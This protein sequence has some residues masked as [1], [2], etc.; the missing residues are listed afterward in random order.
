M[1]S[2]SMTH[3]PK[4]TL[5]ARDILILS[6]ILQ[7]ARPGP[8]HITVKQRRGDKH[9]L[10]V[11]NVIA[12][13]LATIDHKKANFVAVT[14]HLDIHGITA[15]VMSCH[16][17]PTGPPVRVAASAQRGAELL[18]ESS[19]TLLQRR[20]SDFD[21]YVADVTSVIQHFCSLPPEESLRQ[22]LLFRF[23]A[24]EPIT[25]QHF[26]L[27]LRPPEAE[28]LLENWGLSV[29][30]PSTASSNNV[31]KYMVSSGNAAQWAMVLRDLVHSLRTTLRGMVFDG[32]D[33]YE[34]VVYQQ[35]WGYMFLL[36]VLLSSGI[37]A[38]LITNALNNKFSG[39]RRRSAKR[40]YI[41]RNVSTHEERAAADAAKRGHGDQSGS[42]ADVTGFGQPKVS[43]MAGDDGDE[44]L[45]SD[46]CTEHRESQA[47][48]HVVQYLKTLVSAL[49]IV[50][51][52]RHLRKSLQTDPGSSVWLKVYRV[53][54][55]SA[56][57]AKTP[58]SDLLEEVQ[59][60]VRGCDITPLPDT[61]LRQLT[62][63]ADGMNI[64]V[65]VHPEAAL[66]GLAWSMRTGAAEFGEVE[67]DCE[68]MLKSEAIPIGVYR[69]H[70]YCC[71]LLAMSSLRKKGLSLQAS[72]PEDVLQ[73]IKTRLMR[74]LERA[75]YS[76]LDARIPQPEIFFQ[77]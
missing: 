8:D 74:V 49:D 19:A 18:S 39:M 30:S 72:L 56:E 31:G 26:K 28:T 77:L 75:I 66:M 46:T 11:L 71:E 67:E 55:V 50:A 24:C 53:Q 16:G 64:D 4:H 34:V 52:L 14:G 38:H 70:C 68:H 76:Y 40:F 63:G 69:K 47:R 37:V 35:L 3:P 5:L 43:G 22:H 1:A 29:S 10:Q 42:H 15:F 17:S 51:I 61:Y 12:F 73:V 9:L 33:S 25:E 41:S 13:I 23:I 2:H 36:K 21:S 44:D 32:Q 57:L 59:K 62:N 6:T 7:N 27:D 20:F 45:A 48:L 58:S 54:A 60:M 65:D